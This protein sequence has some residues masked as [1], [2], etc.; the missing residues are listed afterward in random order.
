M[1]NLFSLS[2]FTPKLPPSELGF[3]CKPD[4]PPHINILFRARPPLKYI[5]M[6]HKDIHRNY[7]GI[8]DLANN[9]NILNRF[10]KKIPENLE[11]KQ[12]KYI[13]KLID[14]IQKI[15]N[16]KEVSKEK[17]K[18]WKNKY[19][20]NSTNKSLTSNPY[21]TLFVYKLPKNIDEETLKYEFKKYGPINQVKIIKNSKGV[22]KGYG[23]IEYEHTKD[24]NEVLKRDHKKINGNDILIDYERGRVDRRFK[25]KKFGGGWPND[26][27][28]PKWL[29]DKISNFK[30]QYPELIK[31]IMD[32]KQKEK[33][34]EKEKEKNINEVKKNNNEGELELG[35]IEEDDNFKKDNKNE[36][37]KHKRSRNKNDYGGNSYNNRS[38]SSSSYDSYSDGSY[39]SHSSNSNR[40]YYNNYINHSNNGKYATYFNNNKINQSQKKNDKKDNKNKEASEEGEID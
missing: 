1:Q 29:E 6:Q 40:R 35:E 36:L 34:K 26:R 5:D 27:D 16:Q 8:F 21:K 23:F 10:E 14:I 19:I 30:K 18:E 17:Y 12:P 33:E 24:F 20:A 37:L 25:P 2:S 28:I 3:V 38:V 32:N 9:E 7:T 31:N 39:Q 13:L 15:E 11:I 4:L 22:S